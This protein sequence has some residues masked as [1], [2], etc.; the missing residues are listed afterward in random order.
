M[1]RGRVGLCIPVLI[2]VASASSCKDPTAGE[3]RIRLRWDQ[4]QSGYGNASPA[5]SGDL[6]YF[7]T[8]AGEL[9]ARD[10]ST[11]E[12]RWTTNIASVAVDG[13]NL[14]V[15]DG[16]VVAP[17]QTF[18]AG[19]DA[20]T[21]QLLWTYGAPKD[22]IDADRPT[23]GMVVVSRIDSA[24]PM[25]YIP[26]WGASVSAVHARTG[27]PEWTWQVSGELPYRSGSNGVRAS[28]DT[29]FA[30][31]WHSLNQ[32]GTIA[33][34]WVVALDR[35]TGRE[36]WRVILPV[37]ESGTMVKAQPALWGN[38]V[39]INTSA[40]YL[41]AIDRTTQAIAW[42]IEPQPLDPGEIRN[43]VISSPEVYPGEDIV[44]HDGG[45]LYLYARRASDGALV[46]RA[47][48]CQANDDLLVTGKR[49]FTNSGTL[50]RVY[51]RATGRQVS[52][53]RPPRDDNRIFTSTPAYS[54][55]QLFV[56]VNGG[57]FSFDEP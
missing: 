37:Q 25:V 55:G 18:T 27:V 12:A 41:Y 15:V 45:N 4:P 40:G 7:G 30:S 9:I 23:F 32:N 34:G 6:V 11:G 48:C 21:G 17:V 36:L 52:V 49:I 24:G 10:K 20:A 5:V 46:W 2:A 53:V 28:G 14:L 43:A 39:I 33:E 16:V 50:M 38:L 13:A 29:V 3:A 26:A 56:N 44:Y 51:E 42:Q 54:D 31:V 19:V 57:A 47:P 1:P 22:T 8:G 35:L